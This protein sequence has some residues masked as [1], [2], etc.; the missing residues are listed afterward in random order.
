M[1]CKKKK[2]DKI[3]AMLIIA[4]SN[5]KTQKSFKRKEKKFYFCKECKCYH[6]TSKK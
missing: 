3:G 2:L 6:T 1:C 4:N 5:K